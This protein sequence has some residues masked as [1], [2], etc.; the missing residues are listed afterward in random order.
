MEALILSCST[1]GG[2]NAA[3]RAV[4]E[5]LTHR[6]HHAV[7][8]DPYSLVGHNV[9]KKVGGTY[10]TIAQRAPALFGAIYRLGDA[11]TRLPVPSPVYAVNFAMVNAM[12]TYLQAHPCDVAFMPHVFPAEILTCM[13]RKGLPV[14]KRIFIAT[15]YACIPFTEETD[16]DGYMVPA[17]D[18]VPEFIRK[19]I[20]ESKLFPT[21]IPVAHAFREPVTKAEARLALGLDADK[22]YL[23]LSGGSIGAGGIVRTLQAL[24]PWLAYRPLARVI[25]ICAGNQPLLTKLEASYGQDPRITILPATKRM[26]LYLRACDVYL[27]KPGGLSSTE[28]A[29]SQTPLIHIAPIPGCESRNMAY[30]Q[31]HGMSIAVGKQIEELPAA[32]ERLLT[33]QA[34]AEMRRCQQQSIPADAAVKICDLAQQLVEGK[35]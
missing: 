17:R 11:Y 2:H 26:A 4:F 21:G 22:T 19:G 20:P 8:L 3:G 12:H 14:P 29:V 34:V 15:D 30:F 25:V 1:G 24:V 27:S 33:D 5:E 31:S 18:L 9:D 35:P 28:A 7:M 23:L 6:G 10:T 13:K 32:L 16:C